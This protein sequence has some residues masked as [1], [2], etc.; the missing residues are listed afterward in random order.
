MKSSPA[1]LYHE[2]ANI[3][4]N[5]NN[6]DTLHKCI[7]VWE[8]KG[9][10]LKE[11]CNAVRRIFGR[12]RKYFFLLFSWGWGWVYLVL[13]SLFGLLYQPQMI[14]DDE[15]GAVGGM[16][17]GRGNRRT[18]RKAAPM[19]LYSPQIPHNLTPGSNPGHRGGKPA[20]KRLSYGMALIGSKRRIEKR[21]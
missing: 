5:A 2:T 18:R 16:R 15:C 6:A 17:I 4:L 21:T 8:S 10:R 19:P 20:T 14:N 9:G 1:T 12:N 7:G 3:F 11:L 13:R